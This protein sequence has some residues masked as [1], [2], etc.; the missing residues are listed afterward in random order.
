MINLKSRFKFKFLL[1]DILNI[2]LIN[3][4]LKKILK[5]YFI[6]IKIYILFFILLKVNTQLIITS[7]FNNEDKISLSI[8]ILPLYCQYNYYCLIVLNYPKLQVLFVLV[9]LL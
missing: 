9:L 5:I 1:I 3:Y 2:D 4:N 8:L 7:N 6:F